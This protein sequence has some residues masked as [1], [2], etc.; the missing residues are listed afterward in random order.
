MVEVSEGWVRELQS[1]KAN[2]V[3][4]LVVIASDS[5]CVFD[6][7]VARKHGIVGLDDNIRYLW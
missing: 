6:E 1:S 5:V 2:V 4:S 3:E 7:L